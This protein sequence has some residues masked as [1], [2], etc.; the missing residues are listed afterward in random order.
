MKA[1]L[2]GQPSSCSGLLWLGFD[3]NDNVSSLKVPAGMRVT[4]YDD[5]HF[6]G[7]K[8]IFYADAEYVGD[9]FNDKTSSISV[10]Y[11]ATVV[12]GE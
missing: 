6:S 12:G 9:D 1:V 11:V 8:K 2:G 4:L 3:K 7:A 10:E 5:T